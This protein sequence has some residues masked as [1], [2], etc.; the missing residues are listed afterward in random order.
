MKCARPKCPNT[1]RKQGLCAKHYDSP[2]AI[3][4]YVD[5][6]PVRDR[7]A[8]LVSL[9]VGHRTIYEETGLSVDWLRKSTG[10]V[11]LV[12]HRKIMAIPLP[13]GFIPGGEVPSLGTKRRIRALAA[14][15]WPLKQQGRQL[16]KTDCARNLLAGGEVV[17]SSTALKVD[18]LYQ[19]LSATA[20][21]SNRSRLIARSKGWPPPLAW[22]SIDDPDELPDFGADSKLS[23]PERYLEL[24]E[25]VGLSD[26]QIANKMGIELD[27]LERQLYRYD[28][29]KGRAA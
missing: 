3:R 29:F 18:Q 14:I 25:H 21:P 11:Q 6:Q 2:A 16:G 17:L 23:F 10:R 22:D 15:G 28:M 8:L 12:T 20:G 5:G 7:I 13:K 9:G 1:A 19:Q 26:V 27:S 4:G 24:R